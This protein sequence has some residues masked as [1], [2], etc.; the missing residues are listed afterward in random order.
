MR[1]GVGSLIVLEVEVGFGRNVGREFCE[2][3]MIQKISFVAFGGHGPFCL[4]ALFLLSVSIWNSMDS[5]PS[6]R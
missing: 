5:G 6:P 4:N 3:R 2:R 1:I